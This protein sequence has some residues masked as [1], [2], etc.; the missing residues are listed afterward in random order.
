MKEVKPKLKVVVRNLPPT[1]TREQWEQIILPHLRLVDFWYYVPGKNSEKKKRD[2]RAYLNFITEEALFQF[3]QA[4]SGHVFVLDRGIEKRIEV[5]YAPFQKIPKGK[6]KPDPTQNTIENDAD[7]QQFLVKL[8]QPVTTLPSAEKQLEERLDKLSGNAAN[9]PQT[10]PLLEFLKQKAAN[11]KITRKQTKEKKLE[12]KSKK[13][14]ARKEKEEKRKKKK[15]ENLE[16]EKTGEESKKSATKNGIWMVRK[17][18]EPGTFTIQTRETS[19]TPQSTLVKS[20]PSTSKSGAPTSQYRAK[21]APPVGKKK[22]AKVKI[23]SPK[24]KED[25]KQG[26]EYKNFLQDSET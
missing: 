14:V 5:E 13:T 22:E 24:T 2:S 9:A 8:N 25:S 17:N 19:L 3:H 26:A 10:T 7:Y 6:Q 23:Y 1:L 16:I 20:N 12:D 11:K 4:F 21:G 15:E 18:L